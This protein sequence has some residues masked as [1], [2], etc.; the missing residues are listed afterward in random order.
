MRDKLWDFWKKL[1]IFTGREFNY[2]QYMAMLELHGN[3]RYLYDYASQNGYVSHN[4]YATGWYFT[5]K[6]IKDIMDD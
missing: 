4:I 6:F 3:E 2:E 5:D 1:Y